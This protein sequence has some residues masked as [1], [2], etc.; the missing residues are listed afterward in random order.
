[1]GA[2][3]SKTADPHQRFSVIYMEFVGPLGTTAGMP[4]VL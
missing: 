1:M 2:Q 4:A 3:S